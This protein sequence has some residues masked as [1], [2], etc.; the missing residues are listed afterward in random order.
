MVVL[1]WIDPTVKGKQ[2]VVSHSNLGEFS[3][4][5]SF[6]THYLDKC[7]PSH[8]SKHFIRTV[9]FLRLPGGEYRQAN[10]IIIIAYKKKKKSL[11]K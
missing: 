10:V 4:F 5:N 9:P 2:Y 3:V 1:R 6:D 11:F 8:F 7:I